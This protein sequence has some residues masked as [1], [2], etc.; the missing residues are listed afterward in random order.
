[1]IYYTSDG[2][3]YQGMDQATVIRLRTELGWNTTFVTQDEYNT[4]IA[5]QQEN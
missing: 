3:M 1:M 4:F 2:C 5:A